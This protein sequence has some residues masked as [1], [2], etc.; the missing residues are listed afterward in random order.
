VNKLLAATALVLSF[1]STAHAADAVVSTDETWMALYS[2]DG[3]PE[4]I[5]TRTF[6]TKQAC[7]DWYDFALADGIKIT[8]L[9]T[10][11]PKI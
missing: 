10:V 7:V 9:Q 1:N 4:R 5:M 2:R 11:T 6:L 8:C 3:T